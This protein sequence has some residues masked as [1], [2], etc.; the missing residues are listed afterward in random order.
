M[1]TSNL[2]EWPVGLLDYPLQ[3]SYTYAP[4]EK[5]VTNETYAGVGQSKIKT[6]QTIVD[7][8]CTLQLTYGQEAY[9]RWWLKHK[10]NDGLDHFLMP[11]HTGA[12]MNTQPVV[13]AQNGIGESRREGLIYYITAKL[14]AYEHPAE[15]LSES[16]VEDLA[17]YNTEDIEYAAEVIEEVIE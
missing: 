1:D 9:F 6:R 8:S 14:I 10:L 16:F 2:I 11:L 13:F 4:R 17:T 5:R 12:G 3:A 7:V 15:A